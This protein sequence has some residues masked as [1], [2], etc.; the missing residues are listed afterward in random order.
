MFD[1]HFCCHKKMRTYFCVTNICMTVCFESPQTPQ[2]RDGTPGLTF[3]GSGLVECAY[4]HLTARSSNVIDSSHR[5]C[6]RLATLDFGSAL[7][8]G[9]AVIAACYRFVPGGSHKH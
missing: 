9:L 6:Y 5:L 2:A 1:F 8:A 3:D 7:L 4:P